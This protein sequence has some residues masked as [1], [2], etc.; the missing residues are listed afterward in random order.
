MAA[1]AEPTH[2]VIPYRPRFLQRVIH[3]ALE[4]YR[5]AVVVCH[6]RFGKTVLAVN[7]LQKAA[8][9]CTKERPRFGYIAPTYRQGKRAAWDYMKHYAQPIPGVAINESE[10]RIDYPNG[11]QVR[12]FGAD[13]ADSLRGIYLD[14]AVL[15]EYGLMGTTVFG[16]VVRPLLTDRQGWALFIGTP[17]GKNQFYDIAKQAQREQGWF[18]AAYKASETGLIPDAELVDARRSM[19]ADEYAQEF[20]CSFEASVKGAVFA[21]ELQAIREEGRITRVT[22]DPLLLVDT[23]WD[24]GRGDANGIWFSQTSPS[25][26]VRFIDYEEAS[27]QTLPAH[28]G[29]VRAKP[30]TYGRHIAPHDIEVHE[31]GDRFGRTRKEIAKGLGFVFETAPRPPQKEDAV[32]AARILLA[33]AWFDED[34]CAQGLE[35]LQNYQW[36]PETALPTSAPLPVHNWA[37]HGADALMTLALMHYTPSRRE[38]DKHR[39]KSLVALAAQEADRAKAAGPTG[40]TLAEAN[41]RLIREGR[42]LRDTD[43]ADARRQPA[44]GRRGGY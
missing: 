12:I 36:R 17:N 8:L 20:E 3:D 40:E 24:L 26:E 27:G 13:D 4:M 21:E 44:V 37:S 30:Y 33:K 7:H 16:E 2:V 34:K 29:V 35:A 31:Y 6:R 9:L 43:P 23:S 11:A 22:Y 5:W 39:L 19:T 18:F 32:N 28:I 38:V 10:L 14:G 25:G 42:R 15:D 1:V 41:A